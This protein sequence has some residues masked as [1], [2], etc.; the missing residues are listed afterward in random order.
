MAEP[1]SAAA[2]AFANWAYATFFAAAGYGTTAHAVISATLY[3]G[4]QAVI[5]AGVSMGMTAVARSQMPDPE[6]QKLTRKQTRPERFLAVGGPSRMSGAYMLR[7]AIGNKYGCVLAVCEGR[8]ALISGIYL[9]DD[10]VTLD[11]AGWVQG[12]ADERYGTGDLIR[13]STRLGL[14]TETRHSI[15]DPYFSSYWPS[16][17]RGDGVA[18]IA[19][20]AQHRSKESFSR[21]HPNGEVMP[22]IIGTPVC[23]DWRDPTQ[24]LNDPMSWK[25]CENPVVWL[26][27]YEWY[28]CGRNWQRSI[29]PSLALLTVEADYCDEPVPLKAGGFEPR[30]R[31]AGNCPVTT[32][33][34][35]VRA[36]ILTTMD[37]WLSTNGRGHLIVKA[38][39]YE[40]PTLT[41]TGEHIYGYNWQAFQNDEDS[42][43][44]LIV[45]YVSAA[46]H[47]SSVEA[48]AWRDEQDI[49]DTG[50]VR[51][52]PLDMP[53]VP[54]R[55]QAMRLAKRKMIRLNAERRGQITT[56]L[57]GINGLGSRYVRVQNPDLIS[58]AD[59]VV[60]VTNIEM[61]LTNGRVVLDVIKADP[62][63]DDWDSAEE[64]GEL[65]V[66]ILRPNPAPAYQD[67]AKT[68]RSASVAYPLTSDDKSITVEAFTAIGPAGEVVSFSAYV[69]SGLDE[70][71][72]YGVFW[73][74][75]A[76]YVVEVYPAPNNM[77]GG[78][79][80]FIGWMSTS[81]AGG[82]FPSNPTPPGGWGGNNEMV[83]RE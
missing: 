52:D 69:I 82:E 59:V 68:L 31:V 46:D 24:S 26:V 48:G 57:L 21:H 20:F 62:S 81:D 22:S 13:I 73:R 9:N 51:S 50:K 79:Y 55:S 60:E 17:A 54:S 1:I 64:E 38:G 18:S 72:R 58:M 11:G 40:E 15:L 78:S 83:I 61:D 6:G 34:A 35:A 41:I 53:W 28:W 4:A 32:E 5:Y 80:Y 63:I 70:L 45:S 25:A 65:P 23:F 77:A 66:G 30:Y 16:N 74:S 8:L 3:Y 2:A 67:A 19:V 71:T 44:E 43:N 76:G 39:R 37:G 14:P 7:E 49:L 36:H 10:L 33:P 47:F 56:S 27:F 75:D 12:M 42:T 29:A